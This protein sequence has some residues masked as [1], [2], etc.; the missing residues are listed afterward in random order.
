VRLSGGLHSVA[1]KNNDVVLVT[2][3]AGF[4]GHA[5]VRALLARGESVVGLDNLNAYYDPALKRARLA[6]CDNSAFS[7]MN[8]DL[9]DRAALDK[10]FVTYRPTRIV[11]LAA[12]AGVRYSFE[13]PSAYVDSNISGFVNILECAR[14]AGS[15]EQMLYASSSSVYG[16]SAN[17]GPE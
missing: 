4:I 5:V 13:N 3:C 6:A 2:G 11:H 16:A 15:V 7:F 10:L 8:V 17:K 14:A 9:C 1:L 12:Q